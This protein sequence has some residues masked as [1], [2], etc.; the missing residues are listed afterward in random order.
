MKIYFRIF[1]VVLLFNYQGSRS[2]S[3]LFTLTFLYQCYWLAVCV[4]DIYLITF[5]L[6]CQELFYFIFEIFQKI[7][8]WKS[9]WFPAFAPARNLM[10]LHFVSYRFLRQ[11]YVSYNIFSTLS[12]T[13]FNLLYLVSRP[14]NKLKFSGINHNGERG[15][16]T[17]APRE[18]PTPLAG[19]PLQP[20][21][22]FSIFFYK[23]DAP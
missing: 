7:K 13:F 5:A 19:A 9:F 12:R 6:A 14:S 16:W 20:L 17:L 10:L 15:I 18:R 23:I 4:S 1:R 11:R 3:D 2:L 22:Y 21:E 8:S